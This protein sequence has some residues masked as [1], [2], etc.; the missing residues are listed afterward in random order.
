MQF[1]AD[2]VAMHAHQHDVFVAQRELGL[3]PDADEMRDAVPP[4]EPARHHGRGRHHRA[5]RAP[6]LALR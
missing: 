5:H 4:A 1:S 6:R 3:R 2:F